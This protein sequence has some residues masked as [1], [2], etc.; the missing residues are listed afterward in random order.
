MK[1][2]SGRSARPKPTD[3]T[4]L[5]KKYG[6]SSMTPTS[7]FMFDFLKGK[8]DASSEKPNNNDNAG[9]KTTEEPAADFSDDP[10]DKIFSFFF[11]EKEEAPMGMKRFGKGPSSLE[12]EDAV[13][14]HGQNLLSTHLDDIVVRFFFYFLVLY[15]KVS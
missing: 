10:V 11:G 5:S 4:I 6:S 7:L 2:R 12:Q 13:V 9:D 3:K 8:N 14:E 15:R 1:A